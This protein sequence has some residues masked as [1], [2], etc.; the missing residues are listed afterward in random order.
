[1]PGEPLPVWRTRVIADLQAHANQRTQ[2]AIVT[3]NIGRLLGFEWGN[4]V[5][6]TEPVKADYQAIGQLIRE[7]GGPYVVWKAACR[8][9]GQDISGNPLDYLRAAL[10][11]QKESTR[12]RASTGTGDFDELDYSSCQTLSAEDLS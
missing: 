5:L 8:I 4:G 6:R 12:Q 11:S 3:Q 10:R 9:A 1:M 2:I 7:Y